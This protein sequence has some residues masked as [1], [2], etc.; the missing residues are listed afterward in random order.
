MVERLPRDVLAIILSMSLEEQAKKEEDD[1]LLAE[2]G[3]GTSKRLKEERHAV[4]AVNKRVQSLALVSKCFSRAAATDEVV[5]RALEVAGLHVPTRV[6]YGGSLQGVFRAQ[7]AVKLE[8]GR[9]QEEQ[10]EA[11]SRPVPM[12]A[13]GM[14]AFPSVPAFPAAAHPKEIASFHQFSGLNDE[15]ADRVQLRAKHLLSF[16]RSFSCFVETFDAESALQRYRMFLKL[17]QEH[18]NALLLP[19]A[20]IL[21]AELAHVFRTSAYHE[22]V[23]SGVAMATDPLHLSKSEEALYNEASRGT[24]KLWQ[25]T[26]GEAYFAA[27]QTKEHEFF[28]HQTHRPPFGGGSALVPYHAPESYIAAIGPRPKSSS[29]ALPTVRLTAQD[30]TNDL[31]WMPELEQNFNEML[32]EAPK[33]LGRRDLNEEKLIA[34]FFRGYQ[35]F[36]FLCKTRSDLSHQLAPPVAIDLLWHAHQSTPRQYVEATTRVIGFRVD[37]DPWPTETKELRPMSEEFKCAWKTAFGTTVEDDHC[38]SEK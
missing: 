8:Q 38:Y 37:H 35:R 27:D 20:D 28:S 26:F 34:H 32:H 12:V 31:K 5:R 6:W 2:L 17:R 21:F 29:V 33:K 19:T 30:L 3:H 9:H 36:L 1:F 16:L 14:R 4:R 18:P 13:C 10:D 23:N 15:E 22:D 11:F 7:W 24:A 25:E